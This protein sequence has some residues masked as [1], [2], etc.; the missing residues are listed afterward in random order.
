TALGGVTDGAAGSRRRP[1]RPADGARRNTDGVARHDGFAA[2]DGRPRHAGRLGRVTDG[3][4]A[5]VTTAPRVTDG[6]GGL[7]TRRRCGLHR[8]RRGF[9]R[10][11]PGGLTDGVK[12]L[13]PMA[14]RGSP[15]APGG[16]T[17]VA[18]AGYRRRG[19][20]HRRRH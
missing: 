12:G 20:L 13:S 16:V 10:T 7:Y 4:R 18:R 2:T 19:G 9:P 15:T 1:A 6:A 8:R 3:A 17:D 14:L 5:E 11:A